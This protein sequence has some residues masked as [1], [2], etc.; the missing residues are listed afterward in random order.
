E[1]RQQND[2]LAQHEEKLRRANDELGALVKAS[3]LAIVGYDADGNVVSWHGGA[4]RLFGWTSAEVVGRPLDH[5][6]PDK[7]DELHQ[8]R[9]RVLGNGD[10]L[11]ELETV[12]QRKDGSRVEV[13][14]STARLHDPAG[15]LSGVVAVY[16]DITERRRAAA[17][18]RAREVAEAANRAKSQFL[19]NMSHELRTPLNAIIGFSELLE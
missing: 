1:L 10:S 13:S 12:R 18:Q 5:V 15:R 16:S 3:P 17:N 9:E 19:A 11:T 4:E 14:I 7:M 6:P 8:L 2:E